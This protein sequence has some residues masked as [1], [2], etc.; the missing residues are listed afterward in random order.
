[1]WEPTVYRRLIFRVL[2][3][4]TVTALLALGALTLLISHDSPCPPPPRL[5]VGS[6]P[7]TA[8]MQRCYGSADVLTL[9]T[10]AQPVVADDQVLVRVHAAS[11]NPLDKH[12]LHGTPYLLRL[13]NGFNAP[14]SPRFGTDFAGVVEAVGVGVT[15]YKAGDEVYGVADGAFAEYLVRRE[16]GGM[17]LKPARLSF[18]QAAALPVAGITALQALRDKAKLQPG[19]HVLING[20]SG[21]VGSFAVQLAKAMGATVTAVCSGRNADMVRELG[22]DVV[23]D[24]TQEDFTEGDTRFDAIIDMVGNHSLSAILKAIEPDGVL[25]LV[26]SVRMN[27]WWGPLARPLNAIVRSHFVSQR[28]EPMLAE[29][30]A[31]DLAE[32]AR[33]AEAG[34][35][36]PHID[37]RYRL[38]EVADAIRYQ[39][40]GRTRGKVVINL[41]P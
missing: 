23:I 17:A 18:E 29:V 40:T 10:I 3:G 2:A 13:D 22:A 20:A 24:Y 41:L 27:N 8:V 16:T 32:L 39:E 34:Q 12:Y 26:G 37:R 15:R 9:E 33:Y 4:L 1:M 28:L 36:I 7:M 31:D 21:G 14:E 19:Q 30:S 5:A 38:T 25:V 35:L 6:T 11:V